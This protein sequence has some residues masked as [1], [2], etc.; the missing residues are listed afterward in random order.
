[1]CLTCSGSECPLPLF[2]CDHVSQLSSSNDYQPTHR[3]LR[4]FFTVLLILLQAPSSCIKPRAGTE[5]SS[6]SLVPSTTPPPPIYI[7]HRT[8][9]HP[10][11]C[12][13]LYRCLNLFTWGAAACPPSAQLQAS[14]L[15][16]KKNIRTYFS[17]SSPSGALCCET[18]LMPEMKHGWIRRD[19]KACAVTF[20][21]V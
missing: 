20:T 14:Y 19:R 2:D 7:H 21:S 16:F 1:M 3:W 5:C 8:C 17:L 6:L 10:S 15:H 11:H 12:I 4:W 9:L 13:E 18:H